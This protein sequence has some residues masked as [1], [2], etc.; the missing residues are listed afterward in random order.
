MTGD[1]QITTPRPSFEAESGRIR[2]GFVALTDCAPVILAEALGLFEKHGLKV[3]LSREVGWATVRDKII[4]GELD[5]AHAPAGMV[6]AATAGVGSIPVECLTGLVMN[7]HGNA[8]T[9]SRALWEAGVRDGATLKEEIVRRGAE[10]QL[11]FGVVY[12]FSSH[13]FLLRNWLRSHRIDPDRDVRIVVVPPPQMFQNLKG[14]NLDGYCVGEPY[15]SM[16]I[17]AKEGWVVATSSEL[18]P[19]HTEKVL[20]V[21]KAFAERCSEEHL[22][23]IAALIEA[24]ACCDDPANRPEVIRILTRS[25]YFN[26][27]PAVLKASLGDPFFCGY[28]RTLPADDITIFSRYKANEPSKAKAG[29]LLNQMERAG[30]IKDPTLFAGFERLFRTDF[31]KAA[32]QYLNKTTANL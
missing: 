27:S 11:T 8:I 28:G 12:S 18:A 23:L 13:T 32:F 17:A 31:Y 19:M 24:C 6:F 15:N 2:L 14:Q 5:A 20:M 21:Q 29:W 22:A 16:A 30:M 10:N 9:L 4:Y 7:L 26:V 25:G 1:V 3:E